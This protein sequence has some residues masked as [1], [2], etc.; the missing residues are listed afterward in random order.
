MARRKQGF[1][2]D[3]AETSSKFPWWVSVAFAVAAYLLL[4]QI[5]GMG[6]AAAGNIKNVGSNIFIQ[7]FSILGAVG[8]YVLPA[9]FLI[10]ALRSAFRQ[11]KNKPGPLGELFPVLPDTR[12]EPMLKRVG[13]GEDLYALWKASPGEPRTDRWN[14]DLLRAI[15]W[16]RFEEVCAEYFRLCGFRATT[17][18][19]GPDGGI[20]IRLYAPNEPSTLVNIVQCKQ[21]NNPV[22]PKPL[23]ELLGVMTASKLSRGVFVASST[24]NGEA[25]RFAAENRIHLLD[26]QRFL[27]NILGRPPADQA[28]LLQVA[29]EGDYLTPSCPSCGIKL[30]RR[31]QKRDK[32]PFWAC[33]NYPRCRYIL[34]K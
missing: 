27:A 20:D 13:V 16:R 21:W 17:Q 1:L 3:L 22:G 23:R 8:Q 18:S 32:V 12:A 28:R 19:C 29:T 24:F 30:V 14:L 34:N 6:T 31:E 11:I 7:M 2:I 9:V 26:G 15:D 33:A 10:G 5:A 25:K 4:H